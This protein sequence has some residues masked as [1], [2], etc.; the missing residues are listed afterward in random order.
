[1]YV[2]DIVCALQSEVQTTCEAWRRASFA[3]QKG[4]DVIMQDRLSARCL[5]TGSGAMVKYRKISR[6]RAIVLVE[7]ARTAIV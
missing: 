5:T 7:L 4:L 3:M 1:M 2:R 6:I